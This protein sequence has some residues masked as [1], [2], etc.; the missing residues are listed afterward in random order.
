MPAIQR[1]NMLLP[2]MLSPLTVV[3]M[4]ALF[5]SKD[6]LFPTESSEKRKKDHWIYKLF[7]ASSFAGAFGPKI[8]MATKYIA[9]DQPP[10]GVA[11]QTIVGAGRVG[12]KAI[13]LSMDDTKSQAQKEAELKAAAGRAAVAPIKGAAVIAGSA[14]HPVAGAAAVAMTNDTGW[15]NELQAKP[16]KKGSLPPSEEL[17]GKRR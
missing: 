17:P 7:N 16:P 4:G 8:E 3:A 11:G 5:E 12:K 14:L 9:R 2:L 1:I 10:G 15:S 13:E 6:Y